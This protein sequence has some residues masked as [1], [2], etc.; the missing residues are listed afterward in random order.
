M[1]RWSPKQFII[2]L[3]FFTSSVLLKYLVC[4]ETWIYIPPICIFLDSAHGFLSPTRTSIY[5]YASL[6]DGDAF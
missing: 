2:F 5:R 4:S 6:N 3:Y 1:C